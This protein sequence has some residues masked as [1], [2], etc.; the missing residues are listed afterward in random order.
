MAAADLF[1]KKDEEPDMGDPEEGSESEYSAAELR[2][3]RLLATALGLDPEDV[4]LDGVCEALGH[5]E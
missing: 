4:D 2:K 3:A 1:T 5:G